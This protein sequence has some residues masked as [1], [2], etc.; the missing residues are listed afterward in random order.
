MTRSGRRGRA[1]T[2]VGYFV[3]FL[4]GN[5]QVGDHDRVCV[6]NLEPHDDARC[7][8]VGP[9]RVVHGHLDV[10]AH[11]CRRHFK[12]TL[13]VCAGPEHLVSRTGDVWPAIDPVYQAPCWLRG[14]IGIDHTAADPGRLGDDQTHVVGLGGERHQAGERAVRAH[15]IK[16]LLTRYSQHPK[17]SFVIR[18]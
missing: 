10:R 5:D 1:E 12:Q 14:S 11:R 6:G 15:A 4:R 17:T 3:R 2:A 7:G 16:G 9:S 18:N 13:I 8:R